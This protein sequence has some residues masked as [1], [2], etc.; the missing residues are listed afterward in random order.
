MF[1]SLFL[2]FLLHFLFV[3]CGGLSWLLVSFLVYDTVYLTNVQ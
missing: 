1:I 3:L 2:A